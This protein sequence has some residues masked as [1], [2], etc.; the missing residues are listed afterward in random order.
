MSWLA[1]SEMAFELPW[2]TEYGGCDI[3][4]VPELDRTRLRHLA[5]PSSLLEA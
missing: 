1:G 5:L 4:Q 2:P 3:I